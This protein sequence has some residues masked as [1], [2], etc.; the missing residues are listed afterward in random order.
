MLHLAARKDTD[1]DAL[2]G[3]DV[4]TIGT[5]NALHAASMSQTF[6]RFVFTSSQF[7]VRPGVVPRSE[8]HFDPDTAYGY[9]KVVGELLTRS[10]RPESSWVIVRPTNVWGPWHPRYADE[11]WRVLERGLYVHPSKETRRTYGY[12]SN[13]VEQMWATLALPSARV[14]GRVFYLGD[15]PIRLIEWTDAFSR[16]LLGRPVRTV[17]AGIVRALALAGDAGK[18]LGLRVPLTSSRFRSMTEDYIT[19]TEESIRALGT[20]SVSLDDGVRET[21]DW[22]RREASSTP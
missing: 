3:Y 12:V 17:P 21:V 22:L 16:E 4:N 5:M 6:E 9:S 10:S 2:S 18:K 15:P 8:L 20:S 19:P 7:V 1:S 14:A 11:F 13:V